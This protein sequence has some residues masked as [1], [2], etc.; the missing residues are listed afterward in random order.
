MRPPIGLRG[1]AAVR[2]PHDLPQAEIATIARELLA[3]GFPEFDRIAAVFR[4]A[5]GRH[6]QFVMPVA[7]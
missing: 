2:A 6:R 7:W 3:P 1:L 4:T 5:G